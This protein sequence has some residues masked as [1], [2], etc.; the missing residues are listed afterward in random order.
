[1]AIV[2]SN[3]LTGPDG[4]QPTSAS[5]ADSGDVPAFLDNTGMLYSDDVQIRGRNSTLLRT[6]LTRQTSSRFSYPVGS[7]PWTVRFYAQSTPMSVDFDINERRMLLE[8]GS[9]GLM[10]R[11]SA[12]R[13]VVQRLQ[14]VTLINQNVPGDETGNAVSFDQLVRFEVMY[15]GSGTLTSRIYPGNSTTSFRQNVWSHTPGTTITFSGMRWYNYSVLQDGSTDASSDGQV[16]PLQQGLVDLGYTVAGGVDG[17][18]GSGTA[19]AVS[20]FQ[21]DNGLTAN[22]IAGA[23]TRTALELALRLQADPNDYPPPMWIGN[24]AITDTAEWIGPLDL[25]DTTQNTVVDFN[26]DIL[27]EDT[28]VAARTAVEFSPQATSI[29]KEVVADS[30]SNV[31]FDTTASPHKAVSADSTNAVEFDTSITHTA[32]SFIPDP[33]EY[34]VQFEFWV[35]DP[36]GNLRGALHDLLSWDVS[37]PRND[38]GSMNI[39]VTSHSADEDLLT[40]PFEIALRLRP[41]NEENFIEPPGCRFI[42]LRRTRDYADRSGVYTWT[43]ANYSWMLAKVKSTARDTNSTGASFTNM[44]AGR[45]IYEVT[46]NVNGYL[47]SLNF[48]A[49]QDSGGEGWPSGSS[50]SLEVTWGSSLFTLLKGFSD[51]GL[52]DWRFQGRTWQVFRSNGAMSGEVTGLPVLNWDNNVLEFTETLSYED[53]ASAVMGSRPVPPSGYGYYSTAGIE[54]FWGRWT[55]TVTLPGVENADALAVLQRRLNQTINVIPQVS[56][57]VPLLR[58]ESVPLYHYN[59]GQA[60]RVNRPNTDSTPDYLQVEQITLT[61]NGDR[62]TEGIITFLN[63]FPFR[64][65][66]MMEYYRSANMNVDAVLGNRAFVAAPAG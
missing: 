11:E 64:E 66:K 42:S 17:V 45:I 6:N 36:N 55:D 35:Y 38:V 41:S 27:A 18:Y 20:E 29:V 24:L 21:T 62:T 43:L 53:H 9:Q 39:R 47:P 48:T 46:R 1:M 2:S 37:V 22:G 51:E 7:G 13:N 15:D 12:A 33:P 31:A 44:P 52:V 65:A 10:W 58:T 4:V 30:E 25:K 28:S 8:W 56:V 5:F 61:N 54:R 26:V 49:F 50:Q 16:T 57:R 19:D 34:P 63:R 59:P 23:E 14:D 40:P 3:G 32:T 60:V